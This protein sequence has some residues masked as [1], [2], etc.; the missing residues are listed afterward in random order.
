MFW[1]AMMTNYLDLNNSS[2]LLAK[3]S[4][5]F[6][7]LI[8]SFSFGDLNICKTYTHLFFILHSGGENW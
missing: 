4:P 1:V 3:T 6:L 5:I 7:I 2:S 8:F